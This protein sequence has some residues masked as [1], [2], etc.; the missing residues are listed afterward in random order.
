MREEIITKYIAD[1]GKVFDDEYKCMLYES[2]LY[3]KSVLLY[4][5]DNHDNIE[6]ITT[7]SQ[8]VG[9]C[10]IIII[11]TIEGAEW[12][13]KCCDEWGIISPFDENKPLKTG[14]FVYNECDYVWDDWEETFKL[15][16]AKNERLMKLFDEYRG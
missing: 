2:S 1:D 5:Y 15:M 14:I 7:I 13:D 6:R 3:D 16:T 9:E 12:V 11:K 8:N 10:N 4:I